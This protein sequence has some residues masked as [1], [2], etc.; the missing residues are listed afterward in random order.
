MK[1]SLRPLDIIE[2][3]GWKNCASSTRKN[4]NQKIQ[5]KEFTEEKKVMKKNNKRKKN[6]NFNVVFQCMSFHFIWL[7]IIIQLDPVS[8]VTGIPGWNWILE[9]K[10]SDTTGVGLVY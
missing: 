9:I 5:T 8:R 10:G 1:L 6:D 7:T 2:D 3:H 4:I